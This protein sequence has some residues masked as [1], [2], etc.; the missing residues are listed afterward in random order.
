MEEDSSDLDDEDMDMLARKFKKFFKKSKETTRK[1]HP[2]KFKNTDREQCP[3]CFKCGK[4]DHIVKK[5]PQLKEEQEAEPPKKQGRKQ[6]GNSS[7]IRFTKA[8]L[9]AWGDSTEEKEGSEEA[10]EAA[11][12][13]IARGESDS[14]DESIESLDQLKN[15]VCG[16]NNTKLKELVFTLVDECDAL[17]SENCMLKDVCAEIKKDVK[18]LEHEIKVLK[19]A[20]VDLDVKHLVLLDDL[21]KV[22]E[23]LN[24]KEEAF[25]TD[26]SKLKNESLELKQKVESLLHEN[27]KLLDKLKQVELDLAVN[28]QW[29]R[30]S[31]AL[32]WLSN[33]HNQGRKG[34]GFQPKHTFYPRYS[35]YVGLLENIVCFHCGKIGHVR[36]TCPSRNNTF[37]RNL[38]HIKQIWV[39]KDE[40]CMSNGKGPK[41]IWVPKTNP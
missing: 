17:T 26:Y 6:A 38:I 37:E 15:K 19:S 2:S 22:K 7:D 40:I 27:N 36:Y 30:T 8:M 9:A 12:A 14:D 3:R 25:S 4:F 32:K 39:R 20:K 35:K 41:W 34:L 16:L 11:I 29:N 23:T 28:R 5:C 24:L 1:K 33:H 13:L 18:E 10:E 31:H 21:N